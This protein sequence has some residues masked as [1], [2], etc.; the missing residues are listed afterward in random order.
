MIPRPLLIFKTFSF[1]LS[2]LSHKSAGWRGR[3]Q[4]LAGSDCFQWLF[5]FPAEI[6]VISAEYGRDIFVFKFVFKWKMAESFLFK[7]DFAV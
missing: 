7:N 3:A 5:I 1:F 6:K 4:K 2:D